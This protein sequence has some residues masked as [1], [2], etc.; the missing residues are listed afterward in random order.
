MRTTRPRLTLLALLL[1]GLGTLAALAQAGRGP[2]A[3]P[4]LGRPGT[5]VDW[6][7]GRTPP[8]VAAAIGR[9]I[10]MA[11]AGWL[12]LLVGLGCALRIAP[13]ARLRRL[14]DAFTPVALRRVI[15]AAIGAGMSVSV[16][17]PTV[18]ATPARAATVEEVAVLRRLDAPAVEVSGPPTT[19]ADPPPAA[20]G[21]APGTWV[22]RPGDDLWA[23]AEHVLADSW[24]RP[25]TD[26]EVA[27]YWRALVEHNRGHL[28]HAGDPDLVRP[29]QV[30]ELPS[31]PAP[32]S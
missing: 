20:G 19:V 31:P 27:P 12:V 14:A 21:A 8:E 4:P 16:V 10:A 18:A 17:L 29:G 30:F 5:W 2:M 23:I 32:T 22:V 11:L 1:L 6:A 13:L 26:A 7:A 24:G 9:L 15:E 3:A 25:V 28:V